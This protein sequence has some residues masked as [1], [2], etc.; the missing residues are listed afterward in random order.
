M[1]NQNTEEK[2]RKLA[3]LN[4]K[5]AEKGW[6]LYLGAEGQERS[7]V[8][9]LLDLLLFRDAEKDYRERVFL[10]PPQP[11]NCSGEYQLGQVLYPAATPYCA[12]GLREN[13]WIKHVLICGMTGMGKTNT[14]FGILKELKRMRKPFLVFD[15]KRNYRDLLQLAE[16]K[17]VRVFTVGRPVRAFSFNPLIPPPGCS[18]GE[19]LMKLVD[20]LK[21][22]YFVGEGVEFLLRAAIDEVYEDCGYLDGS[23]R[24]TPTFAHVYEQLMGRRVHGRMMLWKASA[25]RV[26]ETLTF[27]HGLGN[28]L[29]GAAEW[30]Y[31]MVLNSDVVLELDALSD[32]D[33]VFL[34]ES[35]ILWIYEFRKN[36]GKREE[37]SHALIIEEAHHVLSHKKESVE[38]VETIMETCLRQIREFGESV[39]CIDQEPT[40]L[41]NSI[42]ANTGCKMAFALGNGTDLREMSDAMAL[43]QEEREFLDW[44]DV[45]EAIVAVKGRLRSPL[46]VR[47]SNVSIQKG[48]IRDEHLLQ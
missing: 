19:W 10:D 29:N 8:D 11:N 27:R 13:E 24:S 18:A 26:L 30:D 40:K 42:K 5:R 12:F 41:S 7:E 23:H 15:W 1:T 28:V 46:Q 32:S 4:P 9:E 3:S 2:L 35:M 14:V 44:L 33:K 37:F 34:V 48:L 43:T 6:L 45:G 47:F 38:G 25:V 16:F 39:I 17:D 20:V 36:R 21:H 31:E 22:A